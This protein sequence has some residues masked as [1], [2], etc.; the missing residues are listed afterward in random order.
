MQWKNVGMRATLV[1]SLASGMLAGCG[2]PIRPN[3]ETRAVTSPEASPM[4][5][6]RARRELP[7][8]YIRRK[9][10]AY[11]GYRGSNHEQPPSDEQVLE[12]LQLMT[13]AGFGL[14]RVFSSGD[15]DNKLVL[16]TIIK[17]KLD[18][19]VHLGI[20]IDG[21]KATSD[22]ANQKEIARGIDLAKTYTDIVQVVSVGNETMVEWSAL[23]VPVADMVVYLHQVRAAVTQPVTADD[24]WAFY[25]NRDN[26]YQPRPV[27]DAIDFVSLHLYPILDSVYD[28]SYIEWKH[29][30]VLETQRAVA[31]IDTMFARARLHFEGVRSYVASQSL[32]LPL[33]IGEA[34]WK[35]RITHGETGRAHPVNQKMYLD[36]LLSWKDGPSQIFYFEAFDEPWKGGDDGWGL[37]NV[38]RKARY[39]IAPLFPSSQR[40]TPSYSEVDAVYY[41]PHPTNA[42]K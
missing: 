33:V 9:A 26:K 11:S 40:E 18:L 30:D 1:L 13:K 31:M 39:A 38:E 36:R 20:W 4:A 22:A 37:F 35:A 41:Q 17:N 27:L 19:K 6:G 21:P 8:D 25:A 14:I 24:D 10:V 2:Y 28:P 3:A 34:G 16:K 15:A 32:T 23:K 29:A 5:N 12:D 7:T 42:P